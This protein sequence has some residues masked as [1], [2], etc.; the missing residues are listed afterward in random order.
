MHLQVCGGEEKGRNMDA[1]A[2]PRL[3][4]PAWQGEARLGDGR[5]RRMCA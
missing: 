5:G 4:G 2:L 1:F 3:T